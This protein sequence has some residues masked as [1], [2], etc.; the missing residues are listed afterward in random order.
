VPKITPDLFTVAEAAE[1]LG[2]SPHSIRYAIMRG[3]LGVVELDKR[4]NLIPRDE[5]ERYRRDHLRKRGPGA[6]T[7][8]KPAAKPAQNKE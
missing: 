6:K 3:T 7:T 8:R 5:I 2:L 4:T 1:E